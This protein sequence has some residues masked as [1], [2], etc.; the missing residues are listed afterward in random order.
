MICTTAMA[1]IDS[2]VYPSPTEIETD[3]VGEL[4]L[5]VDNLTF[6]RNNEFK[7]TYEKGYTLPGL[8]FRPRLK[9]T[10]VHNL[11]IELGLHALYYYGAQSYPGGTYSHLPAYK[12]NNDHTMHVRPFLRLQANLFKGFDVILG[13]IYGGANHRL[14]EALYRPE[15]NL[16]ADPEMG[17]QVRYR[18]PYFFADGWVNWQKFQ[19]YADKEQ[20]MFVAGVSTETRFTKSGRPLQ[21]SM[22][23][24]ICFR[25]VGGEIDSLEAGIQTH[26]NAAV[27]L[28]LAYTLPRAAFVRSISAQSIYAFSGQLA[29]SSMPFNAGIG[30]NSFVNV[31]AKDLAL[32]AGYWHS[33]DFNSIQGSPA[34]S[35]VTYAEGLHTFDL[36]RMA[37]ASLEYS[38]SFGKDYAFGAEVGVQHHFPTDA[39]WLSYDDAAQKWNETEMRPEKASTSIY[40]GVY[41]RITP[42][43]RL[44]KFKNSAR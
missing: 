35:N 25:H 31:E 23:A 29:G 26:L 42:T 9:Y 11:S 32:K 17:V 39:H 7:G 5:V 38:H 43:F 18:N 10:P 34:F 40:F 15:L 2:L 20:E 33:H 3:R 22:P 6:F 21:V 8:W 12:E 14:D 28:K 36:N 13:N 41:L 19:F 44:F 30:V 37:Y 4:S 24:Q 1:Q 16:T 27:G